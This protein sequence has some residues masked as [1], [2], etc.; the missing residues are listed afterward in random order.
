MS[1]SKALGFLLV[2]IVPAL[3]PAAAWLAGVTGLP[4]LMAWFPLFFLF[5]FLPAMDYALGHDPVNV[6]TERERTVAQ[7]TWF[8][9]LTLACLPVQLVVLAWSG[10]WFVHAGLGAAGMAGWLLS[11][12][13]VARL[14]A[15][16]E[17]W[18]RIAAGGYGGWVP[19]SALWGVEPGEAFEE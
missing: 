15:C 10:Y 3:M 13:V 12:G 16:G 5:V 18:C 2:F 4:D 8:K 9:A 11:Q 6:P 7:R 17:G 1:P 19:D 14:E